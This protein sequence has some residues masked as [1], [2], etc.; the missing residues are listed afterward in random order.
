VKFK[1]YASLLGSAARVEMARMLGRPTLPYKLEYILTYACGSRC[2]TCN[3]WARYIDDPEK[4][5]EELSVDQIVASVASARDHVRW[6]SLTGGEITDRDDLVDIVE[7]IVDAVGD[8]LALLQ[9]TTNGINPDRVE[10]AFSKILPLAEGI[11]TYIT[12]S[13]DGIGKT[14]ERVRGVP[15]GYARVQESM[16]RLEAMAGPDVSTSFQITLSELNHHE[17]DALFDVA[18]EGRERPIITMATNAL[19]LTRGKADVDVREAGPE[20]REALRRAWRRYPLR[21]PKDLPPKLHLGLVQRFFDRGDAPLPCVA[22]HASLTIDAYG[23]VLQCDSRD[24]NL[25]RLQDHYFDIPAMCRA[26]AFREAL[27]PLSGCRACF[28]PCQP[29]PT[30]MHHPG[31]ALLGVARASLGV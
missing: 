7:G 9:F 8:R 2:R 25:A 16:R 29:Y 15:D 3:I 26:S 17:A 1:H 12:M 27:A 10:A 21:G 13:L 4:R 28:T 31:R 23:G 19:Q 30:I 24:T 22:G 6:V 14:Y 5:N 11:P 18:S 20:V